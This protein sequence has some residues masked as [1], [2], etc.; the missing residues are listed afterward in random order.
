MFCASGQVGEV[1]QGW[2]PAR[3]A[4]QR[5]SLRA[6]RGPGACARG[7]PV[8][9]SRHAGIPGRPSRPV[10][11]GWGSPARQELRSLSVPAPP[12]DFCLL[13][14]AEQCSG[15][16]VG[17]GFGWTTLS[18]LPYPCPLFF[19][20]SPRPCWR[21]LAPPWRDSFQSPALLAMG[22]QTLRD[23][24]VPWRLPCS[25]RLQCSESWTQ[26]VGRPCRAGRRG[27]SALGWALVAVPVPSSDPLAPAVHVRTGSAED[28]AACS[29]SHAEWHR[30]ATVPLP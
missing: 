22:C 30:Q 7:V 16:Q 24:H 17:W 1:G 25:L 20:G 23:C 26:V 29:R 3:S 8:L 12:P 13:L 10:A 4:G 27:P 21:P 6:A 11:D 18:G 15:A 28:V 2:R 5:R 9:L 19:P 14:A